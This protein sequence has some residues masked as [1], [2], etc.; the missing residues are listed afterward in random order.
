MQ[1]Q[2]ESWLATMR[3]RSTFRQD[4]VLARIAPLFERRWE[5]YSKLLRMTDYGSEDEPK[6]LSEGDRRGL[7]EKLTRWFYE[8]GGGLLLSGRAHEQFLRARAT[9]SDVCAKPSA[10]REE[11]SRLRTDLKIDLGVRQPE[12][13]DLP[14]A[15][16]EEERWGR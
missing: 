15:L 4:A 6:Q 2:P 13:R 8:D 11:L 1:D 14:M 5:A 7:A 10:V 12:E 16:P 9:V 3:M